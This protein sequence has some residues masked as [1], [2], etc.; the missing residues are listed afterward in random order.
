[1]TAAILYVTL[2]FGAAPPLPYADMATCQRDA[3]LIAQDRENVVSAECRAAVHVVRGAF[4]PP[5][6]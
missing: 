5:K 4:V 3:R 1:M 2:V 6:P